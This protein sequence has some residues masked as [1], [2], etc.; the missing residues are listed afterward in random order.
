MF[1][2]ALSDLSKIEVGLNI[3]SKQLPRR[4]CRPG[5]KHLSLRTHPSATAL[6][7][8]NR[9]L[10]DGTRSGSER[11][12]SECLW[13]VSWCCCGICSLSTT[14]ITPQAAL[15]LTRQRSTVE[16]LQPSWELT[17]HPPSLQKHCSRIQAFP[18]E[19]DLI[20]H[21][22]HR[23]QACSAPCAL[24]LAR[25]HALPAT[26]PASIKHVSNTPA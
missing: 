1:C 2:H 4:A 23:G 12:W 16:R 6:L 9:P 20:S 17:T 3:A 5:C 25:Y 7:C 14:A 8:Q 22:H 10:H 13:L 19:T 15:A 11:C 18:C 26:A 24:P 21:D